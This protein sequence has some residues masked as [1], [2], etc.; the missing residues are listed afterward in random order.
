MLELI[1]VAFIIV[2]S[3]DGSEVAINVDQITSITRTRDD[4][5]GHKML[6]D[7]AECVIGLS[8]GKFVSIADDCGD[9]LR[10]ILGTEGR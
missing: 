2:Q 1:A 6:T 10:K 3:L 4:G 9:V 8:N 5:E 7:K